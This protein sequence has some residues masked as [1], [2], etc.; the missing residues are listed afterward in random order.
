MPL[1]CPFYNKKDRS[2]TERSNVIKF[3]KSFLFI[4]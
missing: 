1:F 4:F 2:K 3:L